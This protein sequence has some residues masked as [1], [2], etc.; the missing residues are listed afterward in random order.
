MDY[1]PDTQVYAYPDVGCMT[2]LYVLLIALTALVAGG[3]G[4]AVLM[5]IGKGRRFAERKGK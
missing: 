2:Y 3:V 5:V 1:D 4:V